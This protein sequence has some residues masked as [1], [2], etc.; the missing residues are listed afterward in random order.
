[1]NGQKKRYDA[2][3]RSVNTMYGPYMRSDIPDIRMDLRGLTAYAKSVG[4]RVPD[5]TD[6]EV[7]PFVLGAT[8][9][10]LKEQSIVL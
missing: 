4:K 3:L 7:A 5:L 2:Y 6:E 10:E 1:M 9:E 8:M